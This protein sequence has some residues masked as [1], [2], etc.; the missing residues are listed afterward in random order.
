MERTV[1]AVCQS[2]GASFSFSLEWPYL[3]TINN[4]GVVESGKRTALQ[5]LGKSR[6]FDIG[7]PTMGAEDFSYY[8][9]K[10]P[11]AMFRLGMGETSAPLHNPRF[12]FN[13]AAMKNGVLFLACTAL[14]HLNVLEKG[15]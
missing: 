14:R 5:V 13:D 8:L 10:N 12:N 1:K 4:A 3:P 7:E 9:V 15:K 2:A 6:W 11:G